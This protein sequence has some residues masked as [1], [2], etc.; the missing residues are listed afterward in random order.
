MKIK[1]F[2]ASLAALLISALALGLAAAPV[3]AAAPANSVMTLSQS[4]VTDRQGNQYIELAA[5]LT[6]EDGYPLSERNV[7]FFE[8]S[9]L[10][11]TARITL[12]TGVTSAVGVATF[13]YLT[14]Q[15]GDHEFTAV[16]GGDDTATSAI[17]NQTFTFDQLPAMPPLDVPTGMEAITAWTL[18]AVGLVVLGVWSLLLGVVIYVVRGIRRQTRQTGA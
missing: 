18:P 17:V 5:K 4:L 15:A 3:A 10:F 1:L 11:G 2:M 14:R 6:R 16:F 8:T 12:G 7:S 13:K 9:N